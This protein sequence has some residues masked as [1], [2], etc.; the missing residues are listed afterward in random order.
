MK[1]G[2]DYDIASVVPAAV[3]TGRFVSLCTIQQPSGTFGASGAPDGTFTNVAGMVNIACMSAPVSNL[4]IIA[5]EEKTL[6]EILATKPRHV[7]LAGYYPT[8]QTNYR[9][10]VDGTAYDILGVESDSQAQMTRLMVRL[11][12]L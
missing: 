6:A 11:A 8:I 12:S 1:Q 3:N 2:L 5:T 10:V 7:L 9:A 4:R